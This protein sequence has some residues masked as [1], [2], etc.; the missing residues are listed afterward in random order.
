MPVTITKGVLVAAGRGPRVREIERPAMN[1]GGLPILARVWFRAGFAALVCLPAVLHVRARYSGDSPAHYSALIHFGSTLECKPLPEVD[2]ARVV[3]RPNS[4]YDGQFYAQLAVDPTLQNPALREALDNPEYRARR[5]LVPALAHVFGLGSVPRI[6]DAYALINVLFY[7]ALAVG[8][9][10]FLRPT[11]GRDYAII[12]GALVSPGALISIMRALTDLPSA[13]LGFYGAALG[14]G[15][16]TVG[17]A[18]ALLARETAILSLPALLSGGPRE[19]WP[20]RGLLTLRLLAVIL[21]LLAWGWFVHAQYHQPGASA[22]TGNLTLPFSGWW[23]GWQHA[24]DRLTATAFE[25]RS[26]GSWFRLSEVLLMPAFM[27]QVTYLLHRRRWD[28]PFW[29]MGAAWT[30]LAI[31]LGPAVTAEQFAYARALIPL[32]LAFF[33]SL[34]LERGHAFWWWLILGNI[35]A[36]YGLIDIC[37]ILWPR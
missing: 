1:T 20:Q 29:R 33:L 7:L 10:A 24:L 22:G 26:K 18:G 23:T 12:A 21:P 37:T 27:V 34:R 5:I 13:T 28:C 31:C 2:A 14:G 25:L 17:L 11:T 4:G 3:R 32:T 6:L 36:P 16:G 8:L 9:M 30:A 15:L 35:G 19:W